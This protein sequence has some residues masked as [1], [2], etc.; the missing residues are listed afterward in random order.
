M[1]ILLR[2]TYQKEKNYMHLVLPLQN[3][4][5][6][7]SNIIEIVYHENGNQQSPYNS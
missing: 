2:N 3:S 4:T 6:D 7:M 1:F 5:F